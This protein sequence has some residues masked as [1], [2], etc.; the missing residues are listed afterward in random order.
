MLVSVEVRTPYLQRE[1]TEFAASVGTDVHLSGGG[2]RLLRQLGVQMIPSIPQRRP[3]R[4]FRVPAAEWLR[5]PLAPALMKQVD[6]GTMF[7]EG[8]FDREAVRT[9]VG[10]HI[11][12]QADHAQ[13]LW[14]IL[15]FGV[16]LDRL[17]GS[18]D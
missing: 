6:R 9:L 12:G 11:S 10:I 16:W 15:A 7:S 3:K 17:G 2:K 4:A 13:V 8:W 5:E 14:P 18:L 1:L